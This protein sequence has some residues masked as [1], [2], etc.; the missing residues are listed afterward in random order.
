MQQEPTARTVAVAGGD[1]VGEAPFRERQRQGYLPA[2]LPTL[3]QPRVT[4]PL[5][6]NWL[7]L[8]DQELGPSVAPQAQVLDDD[9][10]HVMDVPNFWTPT[11][12]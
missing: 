6:G 3:D 5:D 7:F 11:V 10:W 4:C 2:D 12:R 9:Q 8:P 1:E